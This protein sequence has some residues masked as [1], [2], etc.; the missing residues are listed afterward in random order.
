MKHALITG[1]DWQVHVRLGERY[2]HP[3]EVDSLI[4]DAT[5]AQ[6]HL[7][8]T[9]T[10]LTPELTRIMVDAELQPTPAR[11]RPEIVLTDVAT[12]PAR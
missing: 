11:E 12:A 1:I 3:S 6:A 2:L 8:W 5:R 7:G 10:V 9:P 4:G